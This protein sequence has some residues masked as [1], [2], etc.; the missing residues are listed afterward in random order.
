MRQLLETTPLVKNTIFTD[1]FEMFDK[2]AESNIND[3]L[4]LSVKS[5]IKNQIPSEHQE[6]VESMLFKDLKVGANVKTFNKIWKGYIPQFDVQLAESFIKKTPKGDKEFC[7][8]LKMDGFR[9]VALPDEEGNY[10]YY[11]REG[12]VYEGIKHLDEEIKQIGQGKYVIDGELLVR[13]DEGTMTSR[14]RYKLTSKIARKKGETEEKKLLQLHVFDILPAE[15]FRKGAS[16]DVYTKRRALIEEKFEGQSFDKL[17]K[18]EVLY[19]GCDHNI[20]LEEFRKGASKDVY[21]KRR[22]LIEE[23]FEGQSFDKL[24]KTEVLYKGCDHNIVLEMLDEVL[25]QEEEGLIVNMSDSKFEG[26]SFDK[27]VKTEVLYKGCDHNIVLEMLD[28]V[29]AQE[30]EGLIVNM[31]DSKYLCKRH[32][33]ILKLKEFL[34]ADV[35]VKEVYEGTKS[36]VGKLG[37]VVIQ[38][39][40]EGVLHECEC[41]SGFNKEERELYW[42]NPEL[43]VGKVIEIHHCG[44]TKNDKGGVGLRFPI[45][46]HRI[47]DD[48]TFEEIT[49]V[50]K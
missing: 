50:S 30:E 18:T 16:K 6:L 10:V 2:L 12:Y 47:R 9:V 11:T 37:G 27:L 4:R 19:K 35:Y 20:V 46:K 31:S 7:V 17:V 39:L 3:L 40:Y 14:E 5:Y 8:T 32:K 49:D 41:G 28:E 23:K 15:E 38:Y 43:I 42:E 13:D 1:M 21:T 34:D 48:K 26:Q 24:V 36:N 33:G 45:F 25:A 22:A 44:D 29:L